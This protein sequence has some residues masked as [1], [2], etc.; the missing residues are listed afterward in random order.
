MTMGQISNRLMREYNRMYTYQ[1][2]QGIKFH[3]DKENDKKL[4]WCF[5]DTDNYIE[6]VA[7]KRSGIVT[8][9]KYSKEEVMV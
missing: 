8:I 5:E 4:T 6:L 2:Q 7:N 9:H 1:E 3:A